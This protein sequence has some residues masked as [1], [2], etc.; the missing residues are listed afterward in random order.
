MDRE[1]VNK[2]NLQPL[3]LSHREQLKHFCDHISQ[4][5]A[6]HSFS[7]WFIWGKPLNLHWT[8]FR[9]HLCL[10]VGGPELTLFTPPLKSRDANAGDFVSAI[11]FAFEVMDSWN[12]QVGG[13]QLSSIEYIPEQLKHEFSEIQDVVEVIPTGTDYIY[14]TQMLIDLP[15]SRLKSKRHAKMKFMRDF[16]NHSI[17]LFED[18][19]K[20]DCLNLLSRWAQYR[21][22]NDKNI[23]NK[24][25]IG[26]SSLIDRDHD[27]VTLALNH[28]QDLGLQG[29]VV[30]VGTQI[31]GFTLGEALSPTQAS[32]IVE[33]T[34]PAFVGCPQFIFSEF[35]RMVWPGFSECNAGDDWGIANLT[36]TKMSYRPKKLMQKFSARYR[37]EQSVV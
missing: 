30:Y 22:A 36:F 4:P 34:D 2:Y 33:K 17:Q 15:G 3:E 29:V 35:C 25:N 16:P 9:D 11:R 13:K 32:V 10:F 7:S 5:L 1:F 37:R 23:A 14:D 8:I 26:L 18:R 19:H 24:D 21:N 31:A 6:E 28:W 12:Q 20:Y 27:A